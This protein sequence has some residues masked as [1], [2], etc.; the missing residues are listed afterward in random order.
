M[1]IVC[2]TL[3]ALFPATGLLA[4]APAPAAR[5]SVR[6]GGFES[7]FRRQNLWQG[8]DSSGFLTGE[9][10]ALPVLT[11]SGN[12][13]SSSMPISVS[14]ADMNN[15]GRQDLVTIDV[16]GYIRIFFNQGTPQ[17]PKFTH[18]ELGGAFLTRV[19][20]D[21][22]VF[23]ALR[24]WD[25][26]RGTRLFPTDI[27]GSGR[28]DLLIGNYGGEVLLLPNSGSA[29]APAFKQPPDVSR[30]AIPTAK[31]SNM[32]WG[33]VFAP[34]TWD[35]NGDGKPDLLLGEGSY[36]ANNIHLL[37]NQG[38]GA[39][40]V[41]QENNRFVIAYGDGLEQLTPSVVDYNGDGKP[42]ILLAERSGRVAIYLNTGKTAQRGEP[43]AELPFTSF[44]TTTSGKDLTF[45]GISTIT[46]GD[47]NGDGLFDIVGGKSNG[48]IAVSYNTGTKTDPKFGPPVDLKSETPT[49]PLQVPS[50]WEIDYGLD[51]GNYY[52]QLTTVNAT[53][54]AKS[55]PPE[56]KSCLRIDYMPSPNKIMPVPRDFTAGGKGWTI[57]SELR[58]ELPYIMR[59]APAN[60]FALRQNN[61]SL[62]T[63]KSYTLTFKCKGT[64]NDG[65]VYV[66]WF[67]SRTLSAAK[68]ERG[69][70]GSAKVTRN[71]AEEEKSEQ[72]QISS[73]PT[74]RE[75]RK[76]FTVRFSD[77]DLQDAGVMPK[78][79]G[80]VQV[81]FTLPPG[82]SAY[83]DDFKIVPKS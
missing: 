64:I 77:K 15:D 8:V 32:R 1:R 49:Q 12:I 16:L 17:E 42:D 2:L 74:W 29:T 69:E 43:P 50:G 80:S 35:W 6:N 23:G 70:R 56:G 61:M 60:Y 45:S 11:T 73:S 13:G 41:F 22:P 75:Y 28:K 9:R 72:I 7:S 55:E 26:R 53:T 37:L 65:K 20:P 5:N 21:D 79:R 24:A 67:G 30:I 76:D 62:E 31:D 47:L 27:A 38:S 54:D 36:S 82:S 4:Q 48:R 52:A 78:C 46:T 39:R 14:I 44:L 51:R 40:P 81:S 10:G 57:R 25:S 68:I 59:D 71:V 3:M 83:F 66:G 33:N 18:A 63:N 58:V 19:L 34:C